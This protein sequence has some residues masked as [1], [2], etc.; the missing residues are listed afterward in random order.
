VTFRI[1]RVG[2]E[3]LI[4]LWLLYC[5][6]LSAWRFVRSLAVL[7]STSP[8]SPLCFPLQSSHSHHNHLLAH[9][10]IHSNLSPSSFS[11]FSSLY[12]LL[13]AFSQVFSRQARQASR[14]ARQTQPLARNFIFRP[15]P[16]PTPILYSSCHTPT[17]THL[18]YT[19][20]NIITSSSFTRF[21]PPAPSITTR[22]RFLSGVHSKTNS[23]IIN[24]VL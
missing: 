16:L 15:L 14:Q 3:W 23:N 1:R 20:T 2:I 9:T 10:D 12:S 19:C 7:L 6:L 5:G 11:S 21:L 4:R 18:F 17:Y 8:S 24:W 13:L 22:A